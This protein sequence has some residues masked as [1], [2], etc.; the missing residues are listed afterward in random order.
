M[1]LSRGRNEP[2]E[3][4]AC[5]LQ[6]ES[7]SESRAERPASLQ[8]V[9]LGTGEPSKESA[10]TLSRGSLAPAKA[11]Y[12]F[13]T[14]HIHSFSLHTRF[15]ER[16]RSGDR[17]TNE[18]FMWADAIVGRLVFPKDKAKEWLELVVEPLDV[19][20]AG[21]EYTTP[22]ADSEYVSGYWSWHVD[23]AMADGVAFADAPAPVK[24][25]L[26]RVSRGER[27]LV[28]VQDDIVCLRGSA[29]GEKDAFG[30]VVGALSCFVRAAELGASGAFFEIGVQ[31]PC[32]DDT[33]NLVHWIED[34]RVF[35]GIIHEEVDYE[36]LAEVEELEPRCFTPKKI[37]KIVEESEE[38][39]PADF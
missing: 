14:T 35:G 28:D 31:L 17:A 39:G 16:S 10:V 24:E 33:T 25:L 36:F 4:T 23:R 20:R 5:A 38:D 15:V 13:T 12:D 18:G 26:A 2:V 9:N 19:A 8:A 1:C 7:V 32:S 29:N 37:K 21:T 6:R 11:A 22:Y 27:A 34:G 30:S 3:S